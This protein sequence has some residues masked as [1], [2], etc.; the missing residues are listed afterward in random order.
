MVHN[1]E[2]DVAAVDCVTYALLKRHR[3]SALTPIRALCPTPQA[4]ASPY[5]SRADAGSDLLQKIRRG[6]QS[7][8]NNAALS[9]CRETLMIGEFQVLEPRTYECIV[10]MEAAAIKHGYRHV[11]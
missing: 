11:A 2:A 8:C 3:P 6:L 4:P 10:E 9:N 1:R 7:A 5:V